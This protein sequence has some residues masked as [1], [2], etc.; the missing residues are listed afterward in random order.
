MDEKNS[1]IKLIEKTIENIKNKISDNQEFDGKLCNSL[2]NEI[3]IIVEDNTRLIPLDI[4]KIKELCPSF[5]E[6]DYQTLEFYKMILSANSFKMSEYDQGNLRKILA[7]MN[8]LLLDYE[9]KYR[10]LY[11][12]EKTQI[13]QYESLLNKI[14]GDFDLTSS[15]MDSIYVLLE[16]SDIDINEAIKIMRYVANEV[17]SK[18][19]SLEIMDEEQ[20]DDD[21]IEETNLDIEDLIKLFK[22]HGSDFNKFSKT[23]QQDLQ[24]YGKL[25][26]IE[27]IF[28]V[29]EKYKINSINEYLENRSLTLCRIFIYSN[30]KLIENVFETCIKYGIVKDENMIDFDILLKQPSKFIKRKWSKKGV[31]PGPS[32]EFDNEIGSQEDFIKNIEFFAN[33]GLDIGA[34]YEKSSTYF[35]LPHEHIQIG[36]KTL[37]LYGIDKE[38]YLKTLSCFSTRK[39]ADSFDQFIELGYFDYVKDNLSRALLLPD[40][41]MFYKIARANQLGIVIPRNSRKGM[42]SNVTYNNREYLGINQTNGATQTKKY[43]PIFVNSEYFEDAIYSSDNNS[44]ILTKDDSLIKELDRKYIIDN[45]EP[46]VYLIAG[47]RISRL[48]VMRFYNTLKLYSLG[49]TLDSL[50]Y[51]ITKNSIITQEQYDNISREISKFYYGYQ[52]N[53]GR[54]S[55]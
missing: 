23:D 27:E 3:R 39:Q 47:V 26:N 50:L 10:N 40:A 6:N 52:P 34:A 55:R 4:K 49:G 45:E 12:K 25:N 48:K 53:G 51:V 15:D 41:P 32:G 5:E 19:G 54:S 1:L 44:I 33:E 46:Q 37:N 20:Q 28:N 2:K 38:S 17:I 16:N 18:V 13:T 24:K 29:L 31:G 8:T 21:L 7:K 42:T 11:K 36:I 9:N 43:V 14:N 35:D 22:K 30:S